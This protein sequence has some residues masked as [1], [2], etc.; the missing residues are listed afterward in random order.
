MRRLYEEWI[1]E[2]PAHT[3][4]VE[5]PP[6]G[7]EK[8]RFGGGLHRM[9]HPELGVRDDVPSE[10]V[11]H[12][13]HH[14]WRVRVGEDDFP[15]IVHFQARYFQVRMF[16]R[17]QR[18]VLDAPQGEFFIVGDRPVVWGFAEVRRAGVSLLLDVPPS[19]LRD[20]RVQLV[21]PLTRSV[22]LFAY[23]ERGQPPLMI[24]PG[25]INSIV[26]SAAHRWIAAPTQELVADA[27]GHGRVHQSGAA[28]PR[29]ASGP[30]RGGTLR[31]SL[32]R[33]QNEVGVPRY[34][35]SLETSC[36]RSCMRKVWPRIRDG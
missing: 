14:G 1:N 12:L 3:Q 26:A 31:A 33:P 16:P 24:R 17:L 13:R 6:P 20:P 35:Q 22:A 36:T 23:H 27:L 34:D 7:Y 11:H 8:I 19:A 32:G 18:A 15:A 9:E 4:L 29:H 28:Q 30:L 25:Q 21:A 5:P 2:M 10:E